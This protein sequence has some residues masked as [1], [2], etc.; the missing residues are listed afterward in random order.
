MIKIM[1]LVSLMSMFS[2]TARGQDAATPNSST[3]A[4][5]PQGYSQ[6]AYVSDCER[7]CQPDTTM[8]NMIEGRVANVACLQACQQRK[9]WEKLA[10]SIAD[11][12]DAL[13]NNAYREATLPLEMKIDELKSKVNSLEKKLDN[14]KPAEKETLVIK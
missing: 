13:K 9:V 8:K 4:W 1:F 14:L 2:L 12:A 3:Y 5:Y 10:V 6:G 11:V 7:E